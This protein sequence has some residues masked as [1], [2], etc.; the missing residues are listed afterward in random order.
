MA[1]DEAEAVGEPARAG[2]MDLVRLNRPMIESLIEE[3]DVV[4]ALLSDELASHRASK[5]AARSLTALSLAKPLFEAP[6]SSAGPS[7]GRCANVWRW[8]GGTGTVNPTHGWYIYWREALDLTP[9]PRTVERA[10]HY[11]AT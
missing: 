5:I 3:L 1:G 11:S 4:L 8:S 9:V 10:D 2:G 7:V 6:C